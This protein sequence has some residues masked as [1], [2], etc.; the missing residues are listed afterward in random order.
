MPQRGR[1]PTHLVRVRVDE[2]QHFLFTLAPGDFDGGDVRDKDG[3]ERC[4]F[5]WTIRP[6]MTAAATAGSRTPPRR[7]VVS[8]YL[9]KGSTRG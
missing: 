3:F 6:A 7:S 8:L 2:A 5:V 9:R 4:W 1:L